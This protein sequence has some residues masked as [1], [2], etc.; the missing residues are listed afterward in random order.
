MRAHAVVGYTDLSSQMDS[1]AVSSMLE[2]L[3][4][5]FDEIA[6]E[7]K[8]FKVVRAPDAIRYD[9]IRW[10]AVGYASTRCSKW[11]AGRRAVH[12]I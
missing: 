8:V 10:D 1:T 9:L 3:F 2:R 4:T 11:C 5:Q 6:R 7:H 12:N